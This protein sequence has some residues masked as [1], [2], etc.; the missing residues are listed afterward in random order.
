MVGMLAASP[1]AAPAI[2]RAQTSSAPIKIGFLSDVAGLYRENGGPGNKFSGEMAVADFGGSLLGRPVEVIQAD[3][4]NKPEVAS[5]L[6]REWAADNNVAVLADGAASAAALAIQEV[7]REKKRIYVMTGPIANTLIGTQCSPYGFQFSGNAYALTKGST[8]TLTRQGGDT[9]FT[10][11]VDQESGYTLERDM[12]EFVKGAG[13]KAIGAVRTPIGTTD[14]SSYLIQAKA[15]GAKVIGLGLAGGDVQNCVKQA[16]EFGI[17]KGGQRLSTPIMAAP[18]IYAVGQDVCKGLVLSSFFYWFLSPGT[19][20]YG[21]RFIDKMGKP[22]TQN[23][24][25]AYIAINHWLKAVTAAK[26][27]E[28]DAVAAKMREIPVND[29]LNKDIKILANGCVPYETHLFEVKGAS[30][31]KERFDLYNVIGTLSSA[32]ANPPPG[33]FGCPLVRT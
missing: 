19:S 21:K 15:S 28:A 24:A 10:I 11:V 18:D 31:L 22:P 6:A 32:E 9:W 13:G 2:I 8:A 1:L 7:A 5:S 23:Q 26:T 17:T 14:Y 12:Q 16:A 30:E 27:I 33:M 3:D 25:S 20:A 29:F 4:Q